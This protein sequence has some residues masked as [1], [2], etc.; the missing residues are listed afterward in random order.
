MTFGPGP[1]MTL[2][3]HGCFMHVRR[4]G[5]WEKHWDFILLDILCLIL[6]FY[7]GYIARHGVGIRIFGM[8][9]IYWSL[10]CVLVILD[11]CVFF[12]HASYK[13]IVR[14]GYLQE[15]IETA[16]HCMLVDV[17]M[18]FYLFLVHQT[19][20]YSRES[21]LIYFVLHT[22][23]TF[24]MRSFR[25]HLLR[26][27]MLCNPNVEK[28]LILTDEKHAWQCVTELSQDQ[29]R[30][31][32]VVGVVLTGLAGEDGDVRAGQEPNPKYTS[33]IDLE[34]V[35]AAIS[36][37]EIAGIPVVAEYGRLEEY[38]LNHVVD[39]VFLNIQPAEQE[40]KELTAMLISA[41]VTVHINLAHVSNTLPNRTVEKI[42]NY[43]VLTAGMRLATS[44]QIFCK[45]AMD[46]A[47][48]LIGMCIAVAAAIL[49]GP[50][51]YH[52]SPGPI[53]FKQKRVG[54]NGRV[55]QIYKFRSM[56]LDAEERRKELLE[57]NE[58]D[59]P[60]FKIKDDPRI[61]PVGRFMRK[62]SIDELP[63]FFN[64]LKGDMSLV[65]TRPP[66]VDEFEQYQTH[67]RGRLASKPGIT[68][69]WQVS[70]RNAVTD[71]EK[72]VDLDTE[73]IISW[74]IAEDIRIIWKTVKL[75]LTGDG[76]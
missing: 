29:Y 71:F 59:G 42:G 25:K 31:Y 27:R 28:M 12:F 69:L 21:L 75:V 55:F 66:T 47:G 58:L 53:L 57:Q 22:G 8:G 19:S 54:K 9:D 73:Y 46:I 15:L 64:V 38:L 43:T 72:I 30:N 62:Y 14:R 76:E 40:R 10:L 60:V 39:C 70:G 20:L 61:M 56:Y 48:G 7:I 65:G 34:T 74:S 49:T 36:R 1:G 4:Q 24:A 17:L 35:D 26:K 41:G 18:L 51:I 45:R 44:R 6:S 23:L 68:G 3:R 50:M 33:D 37:E 2:E 16:V 63:Q 67:H 52:Q 5:G 11:I 32:Q 13:S